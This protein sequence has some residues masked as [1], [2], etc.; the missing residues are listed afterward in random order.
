MSC[1]DM[2]QVPDLEKSELCMSGT[3]NAAAPST[4][5]GISISVGQSSTS[6]L[7]SFSKTLDT[8]F[9]FSGSRGSL[10]VACTD[11]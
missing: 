5:N 3:S 11:T 7:P 6:G 1:S 9:M 8:I 2:R 10:Q 4:Q